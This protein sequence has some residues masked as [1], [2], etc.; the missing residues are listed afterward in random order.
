MNND[1]YLLIY[2]SNISK[3][4]LLTLKNI[5][6]EHPGETRVVLKVVNDFEDFSYKLFELKRVKIQP[7]I[8]LMLKIMHLL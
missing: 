4:L 5:F 3:Y 6:L 2:E 8:D 7:S 1:L